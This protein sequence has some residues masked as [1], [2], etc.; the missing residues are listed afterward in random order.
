LDWLHYKVIIA[1]HTGYPIALMLGF[2]CFGNVLL[3]KECKGQP[4]PNWLFGYLLGFVCY[5]YPSAVFSDLVFVRDSP[6]AMSNN[7]IIIIYT[8]WFIV[9]QTCE[10]VYRFLTQK[11]VFVMLTTWW[12]ADATRAS[13]CFLERAVTHQAVFARGVFQAFIWC[14]AGPIMRVAEASI[15]GAEITPLDKVQPNTFNA[16]K[17]PL[18]AMWMIMMSYMLYMMYFTDCNLFGKGGLTMVE[19]GQKNDDIYAFFVY[20][21]CGLHIARS[22]W[23]IYG[24]GDGKVIFNH[25]MCGT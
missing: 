17:Y 8:F 15:R 21:A 10:P 18:V 2:N 19:C 4:Y 1:S 7:N 9:I 13:M 3:R 6:R 11:H 5:T 22:A 25:C 23:S 20:L 14:S 16:F 12:L 24:L